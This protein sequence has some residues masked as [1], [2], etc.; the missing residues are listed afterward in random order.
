MCYFFLCDSIKQNNKLQIFPQGLRKAFVRACNA[1][2]NRFGGP[3]VPQL[4][5]TGSIY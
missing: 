4:Q 3:Y 2:E 1:I 5:S